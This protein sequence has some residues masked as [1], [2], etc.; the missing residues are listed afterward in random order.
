MLF[1]DVL[2]DMAL[3]IYFLLEYLIKKIVRS[4]MALPTE[5]V[6]VL[7]IFCLFIYFYYSMYV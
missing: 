3:I 4:V 5:N 6:E 2:V 1:H 7:T